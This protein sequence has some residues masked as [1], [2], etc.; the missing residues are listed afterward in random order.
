[1]SPRNAGFCAGDSTPVARPWRRR[2]TGWRAPALRHHLPR[3]RGTVI[4]WLGEA[5]DPR[6]LLGHD[7]SGRGDAFRADDWLS[8]AVSN[9]SRS[10]ERVPL[11]THLRY[12]PDWLSMIAEAPPQDHGSRRST[13]DIRSTI[14]QG[15]AGRSQSARRPRRHQA[16]GQVPTIRSLAFARADPARQ[17]SVS[18]SNTGNSEQAM[19]GPLFGYR[20][21]GR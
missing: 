17:R 5:F 7:R 20:E 14:S 3:S 1:M 11:R 12:D 6:R 10:Q 19:Q 15:A 13:A 18:S 2:R 21:R 8:T 4:H 16:R 9:S